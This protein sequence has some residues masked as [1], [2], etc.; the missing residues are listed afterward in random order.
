MP[1]VALTSQGTAH[2]CAAILTVMN[3]YVVKPFT[4]RSL[5]LAIAET[6]AKLPAHGAVDATASVSA[7][8]PEEKLFDEA[9]LRVVRDYLSDM[10]LRT[11]LECLSA[12]M[13]LKLGEIRLAC[14]K[15]DLDGARKSA[16]RLKGDAANLGAREVMSRAAQ[17]NALTSLDHSGSALDM[18]AGAVVATEAA[19]RRMLNSTG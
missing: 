9:Q 12:T 8:Q 2:E 17:I 1:I 13:T 7:A 4:A 6:L 3:H 11:L 19:I 10:E 15:G 18:L 16:H 5:M 14:Q